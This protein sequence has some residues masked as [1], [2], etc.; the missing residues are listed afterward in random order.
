MPEPPWVESG[1]VGLEPRQVAAESPCISLPLTA[2]GEL[3]IREESCG[4]EDRLVKEEEVSEGAGLGG[5]KG[6][7]LCGRALTGRQGKSLLHLL[8]PCPASSSEI[9]A[10]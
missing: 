2:P 9:G 8:P 6:P 4:W 1:R 5:R 10:S 7:E 3:L